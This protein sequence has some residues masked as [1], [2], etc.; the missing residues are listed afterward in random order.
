MQYL[1]LI[2]MRNMGGYTSNLRAFLKTLVSSLPASMSLSRPS[3][4]TVP[5]NLGVLQTVGNNVAA[6]EG[7]RWDGTKWNTTAIDGI[8]PLT[9]QGVLNEPARTNTTWPSIDLT[10]GTYTK[11]DVTVV[12]NSTIAP[13]GTNT[14]SKVVE[15]ATTANHLL[16]NSSA[17]TLGATY[18]LS[19]YAKA[20]ERTWM[21]LQGGGVPFTGYANINLANGA[22]GTVVGVTPV[23]ATLGNGWY[24]ISITIIASSTAG[25]V[26]QPFILDSDRSGGSPAYL[27]DVTKGVYFWGA[28]LELGSVA[29]SPILTTT[30]AVTR[31]ASTF[32]STGIPATGPW[33]F[34]IKWKSK[35]NSAQIITPQYAFSTYV[36]ASNYTAMILDSTTLTFRKHVAG[37]NYDATKLMTV[38]AGSTYSALGRISADNSIDVFHTGVKGTGNANTL[39]PVVAALG[40]YGVGN[41]GILPNAG[42]QLFCDI[43]AYGVKVGTVSDGQCLSLTT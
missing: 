7:L 19:I 2:N 9:S 42:N 5:D 4:V 10:N 11:S 3:S 27:G 1:N 33:I 40:A 28:Q 12:A 36:D 6:F 37:V 34:E 14:S 8:T 26:T 17:V 23:V 38:V 32:S 22:V 20:A 41:D 39:A 15:M 30:I 35:L 24:R 18:T 29:T 31:A 13:D 43:L 16:Q 25:G 21:R